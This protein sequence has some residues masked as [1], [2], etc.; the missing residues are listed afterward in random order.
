M[1]LGVARSRVRSG[2]GAVATARRARARRRPRDLCKTECAGGGERCRSRCRRPQRRAAGHLRDEADRLDPFV[3]SGDGE[4]GRQCDAE[5]GC[6][7]ALDRRCHRS[8]TRTRLRS[9]GRADRARR[10]GRS[11]RCSTRS[12]HGRRGRPATPIAARPA[13]YPRHEQ[14]VR[15]VATLERLERAVGQGRAA[16][17][18]IDRL[19]SIAAY[20]SGSVVGSESPS[21]IPGQSPRKRRITPGSTRA[22]TDWYVATRSVPVSPARR[23]RRCSPARRRAVRRSPPHGG[24]GAVPRR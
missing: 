20:S 14:D 6:D 5:P 17:G 16:E 7:E 2:G 19:D 10:R 13:G 4:E 21:S 11:R 3:A 24:A 8:G 15:V 22:L 23:A 1:P 9:R 12:G 18:K